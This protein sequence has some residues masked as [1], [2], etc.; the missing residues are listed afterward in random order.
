MFAPLGGALARM[1][2]LRSALRTSEEVHEKVA[3]AV[4]ALYLLAVVGATVMT[5]DA[6]YLLDSVPGVRLLERL[7]PV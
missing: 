4:D 1:T 2:A 6:L 3:G 5:L 7:E